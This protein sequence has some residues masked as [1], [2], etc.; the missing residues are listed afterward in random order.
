MSRPIEDYALIGDTRTAA[1]V[2]RDGSIDW[3]CLPRF[4]SGA[5]FAKLVGG[6]DNGSWTMAPK[7]EARVVDRRYRK[8][9]LILETIWETADG[10]RVRVV[11]GM[12]PA[13]D[14]P[15]VVRHVIGVRG[16]RRGRAVRRRP[17]RLRRRE[18]ADRLHGHRE[19]PDELRA[20]VLSLVR[21]AAGAHRRALRAAPDRRVLARVGRDVQVRGAVARD[22]DALA[23]HAQGADRREDR[24]GPRRADDLA[25]GTARR[26]AQLG[27]PVLLA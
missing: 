2:G 20:G 21:A 24:R 26:R 13:S 18:H 8:D 19:Q 4:D 12:L 6:P 23:A 9:S 7:G 10:G 25:P 3:L 14:V 5:C 1:L 27:L 17:A 15:R 22:G 11:D 16:T